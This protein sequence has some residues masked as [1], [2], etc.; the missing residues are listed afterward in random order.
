M[1]AT[2]N[3]KDNLIIFDEPIYMKAHDVRKIYQHSKYLMRDLVIEDDDA[4]NGTNKNKN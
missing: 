2:K 4:R 1:E 3:N